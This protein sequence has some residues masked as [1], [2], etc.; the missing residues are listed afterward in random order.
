MYRKRTSVLLTELE[1]LGALD[2]MEHPFSWF[3]ARKKPEPSPSVR[4]V[5]QPRAV[6][7]P[8]PPP[9]EELQTLAQSLEVCYGTLRGFWTNC[10]EQLQSTYAY[11]GVKNDILRK[12][13][14]L[15]GHFEWVMGKLRKGQSP[16]PHVTL[17]DVRLLMQ[18]IITQQ[19]IHN[20]NFSVEFSGYM[21]ALRAAGGI[22]HDHLRPQLIL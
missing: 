17:D 1:A 2:H 5:V 21:I 8:E 9:N 16:G 12:M 18:A 20:I 13:R 22:L 19:S 6:Q 15:N 10:G 4:P 14:Q 11:A 3:T 7:T